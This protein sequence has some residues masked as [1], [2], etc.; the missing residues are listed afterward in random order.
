M[1]HALFYDTGTTGMPLWDKP[2]DHPDQPHLVQLA[3]CRVDLDTRKVISSINLIVR[4]NG[5]DIPKEVSAIHGITADFAMQ[6]GVDEGAALGVFLDMWGGIKRIGHNEGFDARI[7][8]IAQRRHLDDGL[9]K[10]KGSEAECTATLATPIVKCP[11]TA[12]MLKAGRKHYKKPTL[13]EAYQHF[14]GTPLDGAH[15]AM[16][17]VQ[18]CMDIYFAIKES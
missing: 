14:M 10:W 8:R 7:I 17:D 5:W 2:S 1:S 15:D 18:A 12:K 13:S 9:D 16:V 3:A 4:P 11:P 6:V